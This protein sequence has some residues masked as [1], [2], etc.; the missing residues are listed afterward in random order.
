MRELAAFP[1]IEGP[2][3]GYPGMTLRDYFA[4]QALAGL[5]HHYQ[6]DEAISPDP[7]PDLSRTAYDYADAM[8]K[9]RIDGGKDR[10]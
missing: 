9:A 6:S 2:G 8:L 10:P 1:G 4:A 7:L 5:I 3:G